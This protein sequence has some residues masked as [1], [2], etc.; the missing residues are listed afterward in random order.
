[1]RVAYGWGFLPEEAWELVDGRPIWPPPPE[2]N[3]LDELAKKHQIGRYRRVRSMQE[4]KRALAFQGPLLASF[5]ITDKWFVAPLG[6][7]APP[8]PSDTQAGYHAVCLA[9]YNNYEA[10]FSLINSWGM[11]WGDKG[12]GYIRYDW[13]KH[14]SSTGLLMPHVS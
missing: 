5:K 4:C 9:G 1:M 14:R 7:I 3:G 8:S 11:E 6:E 10:R 12:I 13:W 2:P